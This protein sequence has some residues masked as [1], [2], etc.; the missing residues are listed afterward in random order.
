MF[1][2]LQLEVIVSF[3]DIGGLFIITVLTFFS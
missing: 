3:I 2:E 1:S